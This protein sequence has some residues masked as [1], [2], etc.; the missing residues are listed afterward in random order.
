MTTY[1]HTIMY[2]TGIHFLPS[3]NHVILH[4][5]YHLGSIELFLF[6]LGR[7]NGPA[8][9]VKKNPYRPLRYLALRHLRLWPHLIDPLLR[10]LVDTD[11]RR[12]SLRHTDILTPRLNY[13]SHWLGT[14]SRSTIKSLQMAYIAPVSVVAH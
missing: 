3:L 4:G 7:T 13:Y 8:K 2:N 12:M 14:H 11:S 10:R 1:Q 6:L 9:V 5:C